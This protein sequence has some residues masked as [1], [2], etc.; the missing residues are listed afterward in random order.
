MTLVRERFYWS[1]RLKSKR[2]Q[3]LEADHG[4]ATVGTTNFDPRSLVINF[5]VDVGVL[6]EA[7]VADVEAMLERDFTRSREIGAEVY[8]HRP[9][10]YRVGCRAVRL[11]S[12]LL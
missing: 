3:R 1:L 4:F 11:L 2:G 7:R 9:F 5:E 12:P 8:T 10:W 6:D